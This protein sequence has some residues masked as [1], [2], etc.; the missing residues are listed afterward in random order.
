MRR[1]RPTG[2]TRWWSTRASRSGSPPGGRTSWEAGWST[3]GSGPRSWGSRARRSRRSC[4]G[5]VPEPK[6]VKNRI[7]WDLDVADLELLTGDGAT[8][9]RAPD[10]EISWTVM[11]DPEGNEFCAFT[12]APAEA[13]GGST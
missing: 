4:S 9:L 10:D 11:A 6:T 2:S 12:E 8:V 5:R 7:H 1:C 13:G 3:R